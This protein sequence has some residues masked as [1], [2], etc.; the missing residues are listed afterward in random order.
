MTA[1]SIT[2]LTTGYGK[3]PVLAG[4]TLPPLPSGTLTVLT[5]PNGAGKSTLLRAMAG[6][7]PARGD[8]LLDG[9]DI[10]ALDPNARA[11]V[12]GFM[13]QT[14]PA[15]SE[16]GVLDAAI[17][18][19][20][21]SRPDLSVRRARERATLVLG[22]LGILDLAMRALGRLSG[23]QKQMASLAQAIVADPRVLL[24]DEPVSALDLRHQFHVMRT[25]RAL[26][27]EGRIVIAVLHDLEM[28]S[29][30]A[31]RI[32]V[33]RDGA[34]FDVSDPAAVVTARMLR[35]VYG[36]DA[37]VAPGIAGDV[38]IAIDGIV[39]EHAPGGAR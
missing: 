29:R 1:L 25:I 2:D 11:S 15:N 14:L 12:V 27:A 35:D 37:R 7:L 16:L 6:L 31:D 17:A 8:V 38:Q 32:A 36:V 39:D 34:L 20:K 24:L 19:M 23:G 5:G 26:A 22:R 18:A 21:A 30:W 13:P 3:R 10:L 28:A 9:R 33:M 4:L